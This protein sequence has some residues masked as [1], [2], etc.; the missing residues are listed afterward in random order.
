MILAV[1]ALGAGCAAT[2][3]C[4]YGREPVG[5]APVQDRNRNGAKTSLIPTAQRPREHGPEF[6]HFGAVRQHAFGARR[7]M[8]EY[9]TTRDDFAEIAMAFREH[10]LRNPKRMMKK[11]MSLETIRVPPDRRPV[12]AIRL[13]LEQ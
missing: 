12:R 9:G 6:G 10:A 3:V 1:M 5:H 13:Q 11:P 4:G 8:F 7:H 2:V